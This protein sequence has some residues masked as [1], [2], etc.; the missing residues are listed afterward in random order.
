MKVYSFLFLILVGS[1]SFFS[2]SDKIVETKELATM[3]CTCDREADSLILVAFHD[4]LSVNGNWVNEWDFNDPIDEWWGV[5]LDADQNC[6]DTIKLRDND[7]NGILVPEIGNLGGLKR[8]D[9]RAENITGVIPESIGSLCNL[10]YLNLWE[11]KVSG[12]IP[13]SISDLSNLRFLGIKSDFLQDTFPVEVFTLSNLYWLSLGGLSGEIPDNFEML[14]NLEGIELWD[15]DFTGEIPASL[16][17][18]PLLRQVDFKSN[19][20]MSFPLPQSFSNL[21][22]LEVLQIIASGLTGTIPEWLGTLENLRILELTQN[23]LT[24]TIPNSLGNLTALEELV[25]SSNMLEGEIPES[26]ENLSNLTKLNLAANQLSKEVPEKLNQLTN[27]EE[28]TLSNNQLEGTFPDLSNLNLKSLDIRRN[29]F[30]TVFDFNEVSTWESFPGIRVNRNQFTFEDIIP[31]VNLNSFLDYYY[32]QDS[33]FEDT[34]I[35]ITTL[36][37][38]ISIDLEIDENIMSN[39]YTWY[40]NG[41]LYATLDSNNLQILNTTASDLGTY[42]CTITNDLAPELTLFSRDINLKFNLGCREADSLDLVKLYNAT[43]VNEDWTDPWDLNTSIDDWQGVTTNSSGCVIELDLAYRNLN[44]ELPDFDNLNSLKTLLFWHN[45]LTGELPLFESSLALEVLRVDDNPGLGG[46]I[47]DFSLPNLMTFGFEHCPFDYIPNFS[48]LPSLE[49]I[50]GGHNNLNQEIPDFSSCPLLINIGLHDNF[51][52]G[53]IP[54]FEQKLWLL[55]LEN[56]DLEGEIPPDFKATKLIWFNVSNNNLE[57]AVPD[58]TVAPTLYSLILHGN[59]FNYLPD[60]SSVNTWGSTCSSECGLKIQNNQ[61]SF[62]DIIPNMV[63]S[64]FGD[65]EY[66]PQDSFLNETEIFIPVGEPYTIP[67]RIDSTIS[68]NQYQW[69]KNG[70]LLSVGSD[71]FLELNDLNEITTDTFHCQVTNPQVPDLTLYSRATIIHV[72]EPLTATISET[73]CDGEN[74]VVNGTVY[75]QATPEGTE[76]IDVSDELGCDSIL[77][78]QLD[79]YPKSEKIVKDT[80]SQ[81]GFI[82]LAGTAYDSTG[83]YEIVLVGQGHTGCDSIILLDLTVLP[84]DVILEQDFPNSFTPNGDGLNDYFVIPALQSNPEDFQDN[85][86]L[87]FSRQSQVL[88]QAKP[89]NNDWNGRSKQGKDLPSGTYYYIFRYQDNG[90]EIQTKGKILLN[91]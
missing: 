90:T 29:S 66:T 50:I 88:Y 65:W 17:T 5:Y 78:V 42:N 67:L 9:L 77:Y 11:T 75:D 1:V 22:N 16:G 3:T 84:V 18:L 71:N 52:T 62:D 69:S 14:P 80:I 32:P 35:Y 25:L 55:M 74:L 38:D 8:L 40:K 12:E 30:H 64:N 73:L 21:D 6:V 54:L 51:L 87:V 49:W 41:A 26:F 48:N 19:I 57:G 89:Y 63:A 46:P 85:E 61:L 13:A 20:S 36:G 81:G 28:L 79:F 91:R 7:L 23:S 47:P 60:Y 34:I 31:Y 37:Q 4:S 2:G 45:E 15:N 59:N 43:T 83:M 76:Y 39:T 58:F 10:D 68:N 33:V 44:G 82:E 70:N 86:F 72:C 24:D 53:E 27:L 56:N